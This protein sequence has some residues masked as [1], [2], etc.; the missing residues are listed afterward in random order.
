MT[1]EHH[2]LPPPQ[3]PP[4]TD[5]FVGDPCL[6]ISY[7]LSPVRRRQYVVDFWSDVFI[8]EVSDDVFE[9]LVDHYMERLGYWPVFNK[10]A[11]RGHLVTRGL[12]SS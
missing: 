1:E 8:G 7:V 2:P 6:P 9:M 12:I 10:R 11:T 5:L 4:P 3:P